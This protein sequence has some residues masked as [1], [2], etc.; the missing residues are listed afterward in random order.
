MTVVSLETA[1]H[2]ASAAE[3]DA[4]ATALSVLGPA[5]RERIENQ[6]GL[7]AMI[8]VVRESGEAPP[9]RPE[10]VEALA[11]PAAAAAPERK[12]KAQI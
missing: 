12:K 5:G 2:A 1:S 8:E 10:L 7:E 9:P 3:A 4:W 11:E 6:Q